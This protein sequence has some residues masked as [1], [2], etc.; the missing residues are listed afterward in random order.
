[1][2]RETQRYI[3]LRHE[4]LLS[5]EHAEQ[6]AARTILVSGIPPDYNNE[7]ALRSLFD[8]YPG[9]VRRIWLNR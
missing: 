8:K 7:E 5:P 6:P 2:F 4:Y 1:M 9:G 3:Q